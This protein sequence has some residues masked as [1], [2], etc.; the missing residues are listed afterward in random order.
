MHT[1]VPAA[2]PAVGAGPAAAGLRIGDCDGGWLHRAAGVRDL[3]GAAAHRRQ[4]GR[5]HR[6]SRTGDDDFSRLARAGREYD[7]AANRRGG[8]GAGG[9]V[10]GNDQTQELGGCF[11]VAEAASE[12][13]EYEGMRPE[14]SPRRGY[15]LIL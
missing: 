10:V 3:G 13:G 6:C 2:A 9:R 11:S 14:G 4:S 8:A 12:L 15:P 5:D 7:A 1:A